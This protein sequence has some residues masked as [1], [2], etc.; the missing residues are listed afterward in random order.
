M[1]N[2]PTYYVCQLIICDQLAVLIAQRVVDLSLLIL[3]SP[4]PMLCDEDLEN[5]RNAF[6]KLRDSK[7]SSKVRLHTK[8]GIAHLYKDI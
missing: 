8:R 6:K 3:N 7:S 2:L 5:V 4:Y 1:N